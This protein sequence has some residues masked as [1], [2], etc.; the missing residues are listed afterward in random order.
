MV[1]KTWPHL[2]RERKRED[3]ADLTNPINLYTIQKGIKKSLAVHK[4]KHLC[5]TNWT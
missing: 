5:K 2:K 3:K 4:I 1:L